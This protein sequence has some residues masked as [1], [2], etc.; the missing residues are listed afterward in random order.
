MEAERREEKWA[1]R[2][3]RGA[4]NGG[5]GVGEDVDGGDKRMECVGVG[6]DSEA[7]T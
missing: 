7:G 6:D 1:W 4:I 2:L 5:A 3:R